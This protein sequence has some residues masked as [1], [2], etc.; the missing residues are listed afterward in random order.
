MKK[1][2]ALSLAAL[3]AAGTI[4]TAAYAWGGPGDWGGHGDHGDPAWGRPGDHGDGPEW[5]GHGD[6]E[7][8]FDWGGRGDHEGGPNEDGH[9]D[10]EPGEDGKDPE[11]NPN[12]N[13]QE[14]TTGEE[15]GEGS[16]EAPDGSKGETSDSDRPAT[17]RYKRV[18]FFLRLD[19][20]TPDT[21]G[22]IAGRP[23]SSYTASLLSAAVDSPETT[24][25]DASIRDFTMLVDGEEQ[26]P[27]DERVLAALD[28][29]VC[30]SVWNAETGAFEAQSRTPEEIRAG[31]GGEQPAYRVN[32][33]VLKEED[34]GWHIDGNILFL[35]YAEVRY[36]FSGEA[37]A[38][39]EVPAG[40]LV[41][42]GESYQIAADSHYGTNS[43]VCTPVEGEGTRLHGVN[44]AGQAGVWSFRGWYTDEACTLSVDERQAIMDDS[45]AVY[46]GSWTFQADPVT[47]EQPEGPV[48]PEQPEG[49][50]TPEQ[51]EGPT[52]PEQPEGPTTPE[53]PEGPTTPE[54]PEGPT[55]PE[56][57]EGPTTPEQPEGPATPEQPEGPVTPAQPETPAAPAQSGSSNGGADVLEEEILDEEAPLASGAEA[58]D[59]EEADLTDLADEQ[60]PMA[61]VPQTGDAACLW[62]V[63]AAA[64]GAMLLVLRKRKEEA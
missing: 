23:A 18:R 60:V 36:V 49:P 38:G 58:E 43:G 3:M 61:E 33:Y 45:G 59:A 47:P 31:L 21:A 16:P 35:D 11:E 25:G 2:I 19:A 37:P 17:D 9:K 41:R 51:P 62:A 13:G 42:V 4:Q 53:Q 7:G 50:T 5:G 55:T 48:T 10:P 15:S 56:Q 63:A 30:V 32:W 1:L 14:E 12:P 34:D 40:G 8:G 46:Y 20:S 54:Q 39:V 44:A 52:T 26:F 24:V 57:P 29:N 6:H 27:S 64:S 22:N 28:E